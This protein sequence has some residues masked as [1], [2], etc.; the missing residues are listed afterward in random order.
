MMR[1]IVFGAA[2]L[3]RTIYKEIENEYEIIAR[4]DND[5]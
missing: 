1:A 5:F 4:T 2:A 3:A